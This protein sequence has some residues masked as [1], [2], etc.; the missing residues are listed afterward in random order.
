MKNK[1]MKR[2]NLVALFGLTFAAL[3]SCGETKTT[4]SYTYHDYLTQSPD[5]WNVHAWKMVDEST[6]M[7]FTEMGLYDF[8]MNSTKDGYDVVPEMAD[9]EAV[10]DTASITEAQ[11]S[12]YGLDAKAD[13]SKYTEG[14]KWIINLNK[15]AKWQDG[16][17]INAD[18]YVE[19]MDEFLDPTMVNYRADSWYSGSV[20]LG[21]AEARF[22]SG[23]TVYETL[24]DG[25]GNVVSHSGT[26]VDSKRY[27]N[28]YQVNP[29]VNGYSMSTWV[30]KYGAETFPLTAALIA[31]EGT[32]G[33]S[34]T[35]KYVAIDDNAD[36]KA[37]FVA[38]CKEICST[39][40]GMT[41]VETDRT[42]NDQD[43][44]YLLDF[45]FGAY[46][47]KATSFSEVG[48]EKTGDYQIALYLQK[49]CT[50]F[51]LHYQLTGNWIVNK[52]IYDKYKKTVGTLT[53]T[54]YGTAVDKYSAYG[55]YKMTKNI[56]DKE[57]VLEKNDQWYGWTDGKHEGQYQTTGVNF[58]IVAEDN[59]A[60]SLFEK[61]ELDGIP[62]RSQDVAK[63]GMS[64]Q[65]KYTPQSYSDKVALNNSFA[66]LAKRQGSDNKTILSNVKF[67]QA[68]SWALDRQTYVQT[69]TAGSAAA[70]GVINYM[71][72]VDPNTGELYR[73]TKWGKK[74]ITDVYGDSTTG[75]D[76]EK[77]KELITEACKEENAST[78]EG[79]WKTGTK[80]VLDWS[81]YNEGWDTAINFM[82]DNF[83]KATV[84]TPL[85][86][87][88]EIKITHNGDTVQDVV[89]NGEADMCMD[90]WGGSEMDPYG[91]PD[92]W[93]D[94]DNRTC[95]GYNPDGES[96][97][98]DLN[99]DGTISKDETL[100]N[101]QWYNELTGGIY[102]AA[103]A[104]VDTR[105]RILSELEEYMLKK[106]YFISVRARQSIS[107]DSFRIKQGT[108]TYLQLVGFG[109]IRFMTY[110][111]TDQEWS[112]YC[113]SHT[114]DYSK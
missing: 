47:S 69:Q 44:I 92:T 71:Y 22:K 12:K 7:G 97:S 17:A 103:S 80:V 58:Q 105:V 29:W 39:A 14:Q 15:Q 75:Y 5:T 9:G 59:T 25:D 65:L 43:N 51:Q 16:T 36:V 38:A 76:L 32:W 100:S 62:V 46:A 23:R 113:G 93:I 11:M 84:G 10:D 111:M 82:I 50:L 40:F 57:I 45:L 79:S 107:M 91:I 26:A 41:L 114:L 112:D 78:K 67:R 66:S 6:I 56:L 1:W 21:H 55:P 53:A 35:P 3:T 30:D 72:V 73:N 18:T 34:S 94:A 96:I 95:Y 110:T 86:G 90:I 106:Q 101:T 37:K 13:G 2:V 89:K 24:V 64:S 31:D 70:L 60:L 28:L 87:L 54:E 81:V 20:V 68:L 85:E 61:G 102:S 99:D 104:S 42:D 49:P 83:T 52:T 19:S 4:D 77:A 48:I 74:V 108:D 8:A 27:A 109:G 63:Y 33:N 88:F 98:I